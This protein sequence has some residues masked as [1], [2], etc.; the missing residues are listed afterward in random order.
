MR[1]GKGSVVKIDEVEID[2]VV[3]ALKLAK[4]E[5]MCEAHENMIGK[6]TAQFEALFL[7]MT[8]SGS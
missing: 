8:L 5:P 2:L 4:N 1:I 6:L 7:E 3:K